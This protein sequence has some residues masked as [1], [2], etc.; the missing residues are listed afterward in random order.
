MKNFQTYA[1]Y[2]DVIYQEKNYPKEVDFLIKALKKYSS[3][4]VKNI[5]SLGC[6]T[7]SYEIL[8]AKKGFNI[9]GVDASEKMLA[10][11][12]EKAVREQVKITLKKADVSR[13]SVSKKYDVAMA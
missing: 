1:K 6:G 4:P 3:K 5:L 10:I 9:L 8:L 13:F 2:Y 11:A 7:A 12:K